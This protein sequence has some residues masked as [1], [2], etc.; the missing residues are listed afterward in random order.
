MR[1]PTKMLG[2]AS[3][4]VREPCDQ[5]DALFYRPRP[6]SATP[7]MQAVPLETPLRLPT[8]QS[9]LGRE[10]KALCAC[11]RA[12]RESERLKTCSREHEHAGHTALDSHCLYH[13]HS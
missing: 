7:T 13:I 10:G 5:L 12:N 4:G 3:K 9:S 2:R 1:L 11:L 8:S 6:Y